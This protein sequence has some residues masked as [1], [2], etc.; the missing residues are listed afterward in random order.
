MLSLTPISPRV[1]IR[2]S[3]Y[4]NT[5]MW[6]SRVGHRPAKRSIGRTGLLHHGAAGDP[7]DLIPGHVF[8]QL[9][10]KSIRHQPWHPSVFLTLRA[11]D[12][13]GVASAS[14][15]A[16]EVSPVVQ[17]VGQ[18][19]LRAGAADA[20]HHHGVGAHLPGPIPSLLWRGQHISFSVRCHYKHGGTI[21]CY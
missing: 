9:R 8:S 4:N 10:L 18:R 19:H 2:T 3:T 20:T 11:G 7:F 16:A 14:F 21:I 6:T 12:S 5:S 17:A 15:G 13:G 1:N